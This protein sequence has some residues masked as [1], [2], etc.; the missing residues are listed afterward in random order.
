MNHPSI[1]VKY[2]F[3][4]LA[5]CLA[6]LLSFILMT[7]L[8]TGQL[9][10]QPEITL[11]WISIPNFKPL[12]EK[13]KLEIIEKT[14]KMMMPAE[15]PP[16]HNGRLILPETNFIT[17]TAYP[18]LRIGLLLADIATPEISSPVKDLIP[19]LVV[20]PT[21]PFRATIKQ[22]E[23]FVL[24]QFSVRENGTVRN[25]FIIESEPGSLFDDAAL[26]AVIKFKFIP[27]QVAGEPIAVENVKIRF[28]F[29]LDSPSYIDPAYVDE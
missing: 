3:V 27:R 11:P 4:G 13:R 10:R 26:S 17:K 18:I 25:P 23:G 9:N 24:V 29:K 6:T 16:D 14:E 2:L 22:I 15:M 21:Y 20:Q 5:A 19:L 7:L 28:L 8:I 12:R 1:P